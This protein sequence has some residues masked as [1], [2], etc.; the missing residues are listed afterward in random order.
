[1]TGPSSKLASEN[2]FEGA[3]DS[4]TFGDYLQAAGD[5]FYEDFTLPVGVVAPSAGAHV[6]AATEYS[7]SVLKGLKSSAIGILGVRQAEL[8]TNVISA[9]IDFF[10]NYG[11]SALITEVG[12]ME[13]SE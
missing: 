10:L 1:M 11:D 4:W 7:T 13:V 8:A 5:A 3:G 2:A 9:S 6:D 12:L